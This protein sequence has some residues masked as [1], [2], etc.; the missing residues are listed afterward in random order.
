[1]LAAQKMEQ[2]RSLRWTRTRIGT[3]AVSVAASDRSTDLSSDPPTAAGR[4][5]SPSPAGTLES[6]IP[7]YVDYLDAAGAWVGRGATSPH[8]GVYVRRWAVQPLESDP[9][10]ILLLQ[11]VVTTTG[12]STHE[13]RLVSVLTRRP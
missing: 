7:P 1:V 2:L 12:A 6:N 8:T 11:V 13:S 3:S 4:G 5:L 10:D 9:D